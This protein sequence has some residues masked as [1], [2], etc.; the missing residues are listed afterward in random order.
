VVEEFPFKRSVD[1]ER[2]GNTPISYP[3][4]VITVTGMEELSFAADLEFYATPVEFKF[5]RDDLVGSTIRRNSRN[6][7]SALTI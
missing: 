6:T 3:Y 5:R 2:T 4:V 7:S 1:S